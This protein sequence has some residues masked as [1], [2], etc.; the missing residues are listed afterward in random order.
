ME[1]LE[2]SDLSALVRSRGALPPDEAIDFV[3]QACEAIAEAH[4][5]GIVHRDLKPANLFVVRRPDGALAIKVLDFGISK[6]TNMLGTGF[7]PGASMT[8][9]TAILGSPLYMSPEQLTSTR[10]VDVRADV[11][12]LGVILHELLTGHVPFEAET[13]PQLSIMIVQQAPPPLRTLRPELPAELEAVVGRCLAKDRNLRFANVAELALALGELAPARS[14]LSIER[15]VQ[16]LRA[17]GIEA[18]PIDLAASG[19][20]NPGTLVSFGNTHRGKIPQGIWIGVATGLGV[21]AIAGAVLAL[22]IRKASPAPPVGLVAASTVVALPAP[23]AASVPAVVVSAPI[24]PPAPG[25][26]MASAPD[27]APKTPG[28]KAPAK[29]GGSKPAARE[30]IGWDDRR[31]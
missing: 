12:S 7:G 11:W 24:E 26:S 15:I 17:A 10:D 8:R 25:A 4:S 31:K 9:T 18:Q 6:M 13:L 3:L 28:R 27:A 1:Y 5:L 2:G 23:P 29:T 14:R 16:V 20:A 21:V 30:D 19:S 22:W